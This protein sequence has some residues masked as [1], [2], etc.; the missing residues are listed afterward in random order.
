MLTVHQRYRRT[1]GRTNVY[2]LRTT[3]DSN[4]ALCTIRISRG[5]NNRDDNV[6]VSVFRVR[7]HSVNSMGGAR[8]CERVKGEPITGVWRQNPKRGPGGDAP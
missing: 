3:Y 7:E 1:D 6:A 8:I 4:T 2:G 5:G